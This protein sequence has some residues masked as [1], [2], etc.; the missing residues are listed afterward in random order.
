MDGASEFERRFGRAPQVVASALGRICLIGEHVDY[1]GGRVVTAAVDR[2]TR[3]WL[4]PRDDGRIALENGLDAYAAHTQEARVLRD[5]SFGGAR[6]HDYVLSVASLLDARFGERCSAG[7]GFDAFVSSDLPIAAGLSS[8]ASLQVAVAEAFHTL[9]GLELPQRDVWLLCQKAETLCG[10][11][12]GIMDQIAV[13]REARRGQALL[14]DCS[15][16]AVEARFPVPPEVAFV[17]APS[18]IK[19]D[20]AESEYN[21]RVAVGLYALSCILV[22]LA[23]KSPSD[24][25]YEWLAAIRAGESLSRLLERGCT[26]AALVSGTE[27]RR[28]EIVDA[29]PPEVTL[30]TLESVGI[31]VGGMYWRR[32]ENR[33]ALAARRLPVR[34]NLQHVLGEM[35]RTRQFLDAFVRGDLA[36]AGKLMD[37]THRSLTEDYQ[38]G[39][40]EGDL[41]AEL[42]RSHGAAG[43][44]Q[45]GA[46]FGGSVL[47]MV[48]AADAER[49]ASRVADSYRAE[50]GIEIAPIV[51]CPADGAS[52]ERL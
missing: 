9:D 8:S 41:L 43:A 46:G 31:A 18:R 44:R 5:Q 45:V 20:K 6:W 11:D 4:A 25:V 30:E 33:H 22:R 10:Q 47:G 15:A 3:V 13:S 50:S 39:W 7:G 38:A 52:A 21:V 42:F 1:H 48:R 28:E 40:A 19:A 23:G 26:L 27:M 37:E 12:S 35:E 2:R 24:R 51:V 17:A 34:R 29:V 14:I 49:V 32:E 16:P 36:E